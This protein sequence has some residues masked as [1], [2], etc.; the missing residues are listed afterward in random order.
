MSKE[1]STVID[2]SERSANSAGRRIAAAKA[3]IPRRVPRRTKDGFAQ[4]RQHGRRFVEQDAAYFC[5][6]AS[7]FAVGATEAVIESLAA[8]ICWAASI[9]F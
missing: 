6:L 1:S 8:P 3:Q 2:G 4:G 5:G 9:L 7:G